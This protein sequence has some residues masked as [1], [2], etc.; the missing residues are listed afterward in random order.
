MLTTS[1]GQRTQSPEGH[2]CCRDEGKGWHM[3]IRWFF[4]QST[5]KRTGFPQKVGLYISPPMSGIRETIRI[6]FTPIPEGSFTTYFFDVW[7]KVSSHALQNS[8]RL[9]AYLQFLTL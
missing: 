8:Y 1:L 3:R 7:E 6:N 5:W 4:S 9:P 2:T